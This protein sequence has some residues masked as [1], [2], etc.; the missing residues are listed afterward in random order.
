M[1]EQTPEVPDTVAEKASSENMDVETNSPEDLAAEN[2]GAAK[3]PREEGDE[4]DNDDNGDASKKTKVQNPEEEQ[5]VETLEGKES[6]AEGEKKEDKSGP[7][8]LGPKTFV[9]SVEM[10]D[11]FYKLLHSWSTNLNVNKYEHLVLLELLNKGHPEPE[12]KIGK[13]VG[14]FQVRFHPKY[15]SRCFFITGED[16]S[17]DDFSFRKCVDN[18]LPL[19]ENMPIKHDTYRGERGGRGGGRWGGRGRGHGRGRFRN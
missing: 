1:A 19:P 4:P 7:V 15:K 10:F 12:K 9:S 5:K 16:G 2:G 3:R 6:A 8:T 14:G 13:G 11:Y 18:I 17:S